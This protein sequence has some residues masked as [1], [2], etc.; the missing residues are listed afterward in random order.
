MLSVE[1]STLL[2][3]GAIALIAGFWQQAKNTFQYLSSFFIIQAE[4]PDSLSHTIRTYLKTNYKLLP[5]GLYHYES[6]FFSKSMSSSTLEAPF[7]LENPKISIYYKGFKFILF[8]RTSNSMLTIRGIVNFDH[9]ISSALDLNIRQTED[10][11]DKN[12][13]RY[14]VLRVTGKDKWNASSS[15]RN[16]NNSSGEATT[17]SSSKKSTGQSYAQVGV[18]LR[19]DSSFKYS[20]KEVFNSSTK[21][22]FE[23]LYYSEEVLRYVNQAKTWIKMSSWYEERQIPWRRGWALAG[24]GGTGKSSLAKAL[25]QTLRIPIYHYYLATLSDQEFMSEW[26]VMQSP[27]MVLFEDFDTV[28]DKRTPLTEHKSLTFEC[29]LNQIS[30]VS[31]MNGVFFVLTTNHLDKIDEAMGVFS[32][33]GE[34]STRPGRIDTVIHLG[35]ITQENKVRMANQ[36]LKDWPHLIKAVCEHPC[37][38]TPVQF[39]EMCTQQ[40]FRQLQKGYEAKDSLFEALGVSQ[41]ITPLP[42]SAYLVN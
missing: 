24:P 4:F 40:A 7:R 19:I 22:P 10:V 17:I 14:Q 25:A 27:C 20:D 42:E 3:G 26:G 41:K 38:V 5:S 34:I 8:K 9:V 15:G 29:V 16:E 30:G 37:E 18:N 23:T 36:I 31:S 39:Q 32:G 11:S 35:N 2:A 21:D 28:F 12:N 6:V 33:N 1:P 13:S